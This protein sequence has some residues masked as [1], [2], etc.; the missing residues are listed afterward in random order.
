MSYR[1]QNN[2]LRQLLKTARNSF[3]H[4]LLES[5]ERG[6]YSYIKGTLNSK[7]SQITL[8]DETSNRLVVEPGMM[9]EMFAEQFSRNYEYT[10]YTISG[11]GGYW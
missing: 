5:G 8:T 2:N 7:C 9:A 6:F 1:T 10:E 11:S 3:V 4:G